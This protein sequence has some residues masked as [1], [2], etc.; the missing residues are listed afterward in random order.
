MVDQ[1]GSI[2]PDTVQEDHVFRTWDQLDA[3]TQ[4]ALK[5]ADD[6]IAHQMKIYDARQQSLR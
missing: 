4:A 5:K 2:Q 3:N 1:N 6:L